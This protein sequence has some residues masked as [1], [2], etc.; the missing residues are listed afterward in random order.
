[1]LETPCRLVL[2]GRVFP[3]LIVTGNLTVKYFILLSITIFEMI[4][5]TVW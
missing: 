2:F 3:I 5:H 1:M 4:P